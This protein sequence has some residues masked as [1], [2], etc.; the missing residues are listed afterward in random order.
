MLR[1]SASFKALPPER[2]A[3]ILKNTQK[4]FS[5][6]ADIDYPSGSGETPADLVQAVDFPGFVSDLIQGVFQAI[7]DTSVQQMEAYSELLGN[8]AESVDQFMKDDTSEDQALDYLVTRYPD[9]FQIEPESGRIAPKPDI[10]AGSAQNFMPSPRLPI[11]FK[12][13]GNEEAEKELVTRARREIAMDRQQ[14]LATMVMKGLKSILVTEKRKS[15]EMEK[16]TRNSEMN[17]HQGTRHFP[18]E[19]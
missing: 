18:W 5:F 3:K 7:V 13:C 11:Q 9:Y 6:I 2:Q 1:R 10:V 12:D 16:D 14:L 8:V 19:P 15:T 17:E 4:V